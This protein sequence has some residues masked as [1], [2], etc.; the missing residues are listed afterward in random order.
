[1]SQKTLG[2]AV[3]AALT[4]GGWAISAA[5]A[6]A[7]PTLDPFLGSA[8]NVDREKPEQVRWVCNRWGRCWWRRSHW[9]PRY[10]GRHYWRGRHHWRHRGWRHHGPRRHWR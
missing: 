6:A 4:F 9:G 2:L 1:M 7:A 8:A 10:Y 5:P 3:A